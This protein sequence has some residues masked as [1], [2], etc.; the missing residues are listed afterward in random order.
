MVRGLSLSRL[1]GHTIVRV[2]IEEIRY[3]CTDYLEIDRYL[4]IAPFTRFAGASPD[5]GRFSSVIYQHGCHFSQKFPGTFREAGHYLSKLGKVAACGRIGCSMAAG[6]IGHH[7]VTLVPVFSFRHDPWD[8]PLHPAALGASPVGGRRPRPSFTNSGDNS[9][10][11]FPGTFGEAGHYLSKLGKVAAC[12]RIGCS[13]VARSIGLN[14]VTLVPAFPLRRVPWDS[15]LHPALPGAFPAP[16]RFSSVIY[17]HECHFSQKFPGTFREIGHYL[18]KL[19]KV[20]A[21]GRIG[22]SMAA[23]SIGLNYGTPVPAFP[24]R[25]VPWDSPATPASR[26]LPPLGDACLTSY[27]PT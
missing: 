13:M 22:C 16:G 4:G 23:R 27:L 2:I 17:R 21:C 5:G 3:A 9:P 10:Q 15:P 6:T 14:Y 11:K 8:S 20:A 7:Y 12:G 24:L 1:K 26:E 18:S 25:H 19:G